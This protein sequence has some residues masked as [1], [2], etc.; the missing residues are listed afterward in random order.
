TT[1]GLIAEIHRQ[2]GVAIAAH[3]GSFDDW[4][5]AGIDGMEVY[6]L[7]DDVRDEFLPF[8]IP[9]WLWEYRI[10]PV[11]AMAA[12]LDYP[13]ANLR[14]WDAHAARR[15]F[16]GIAGNDAHQNLRIGSWQID[17][18]ARQ[19]SMVQ[20]W[21]TAARLTRADVLGAIRAGRASV[22]FRAF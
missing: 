8:A 20:T 16:T 3:P 19:F 9:R 18:Y 4:N 5:A 14:T 10:D 11:R 2:G 21:V 6:D 13:A 1:G 12:F 7:F 15:P 22:V 17:P